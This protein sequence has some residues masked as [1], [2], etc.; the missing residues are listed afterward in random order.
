MSRG[1]LP[2]L[3][4]DFL[5]AYLR[6]P[7]ADWKKLLRSAVDMSL[8]GKYTY[9]RL[10]RRNI[11]ASF[12]PFP[13]RGPVIGGVVV[14]IDCSGS[15]QEFLESFMIEVEAIS[16]TIECDGFFLM[17]HDVNVYQ[18]EMIADFSSDKVR[19][20]RG[21]TSHL[22][23]F[24]VVER[25]HDT[26]KLPFTP[27]VIVCLTDLETKFPANCSVKTIWVAPESKVAPVPFGTIIPIS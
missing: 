5:L 1:D 12:L 6:P 20:T 4:E 19:V 15:T 8:R 11:D 10:N 13:R 2:G 18:A 3:V 26:I 22:D 9:G 21:G 14:A 17:A 27:K 24:S 23:V 25:Q 16:K 7:K